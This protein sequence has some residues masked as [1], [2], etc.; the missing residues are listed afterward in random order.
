MARQAW[1]LV[2]AVSCAAVLGLA[3]QAET[4][5]SVGVLEEPEPINQGPSVQGLHARVLNWSATGGS[6]KEIPGSPAGTVVYKQQRM[7]NMGACSSFCNTGCP[8]L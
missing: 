6:F 7:A 5:D 2:L 4:G 3:D 1:L 8:H